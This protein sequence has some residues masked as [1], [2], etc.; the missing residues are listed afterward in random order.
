M[1]SGRYPITVK[2]RCND[3]GRA[4]SFDHYDAIIAISDGHVKTSVTAAD[5]IKI[6]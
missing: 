2:A 3:L 6:A 4:G 5:V 1:I